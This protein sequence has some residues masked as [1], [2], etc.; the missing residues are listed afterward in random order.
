MV[1]V[2]GGQALVP[3]HDYVGRAMLY[4][5]DL[6]RKVSCVIDKVVRPGDVALD[7]GANLG[8]VSLRLA[9]QVGAKGAV[10]AFEPSPRLEPYLTTTF[11]ANPG[12]NIHHHPVALGSERDELLLHIPR[13][14]AG[15]ATLRTEGSAVAT[16]SISVPV[17]PLDEYVQDHSI[18]RIDFV[19]IDVE[20]FEAAVI[21]GGLK[22]FAEL[23][24]KAIIFEEHAN[25]NAGKPAYFMKLSEIGFDI[26]ALPKRF[27]KLA[28]VP[29][30]GKKIPDSHDYVAL[31]RDTE[32]ELTEFIT[33]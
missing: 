29:I 14:N 12:L 33:Q 17:Y 1:K 21:Q 22:T 26:F 9:K 8:L 4:V 20:G 13:A 25:L 15:A 5:G 31:C 23:R 30:E 19:K 11:D 10:H 28:L 27:F 32:T 18:N 2:E 6:D 24:P 3:T 16:E 7:I